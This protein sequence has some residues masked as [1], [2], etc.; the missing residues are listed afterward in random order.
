MDLNHKI[1]FGALFVA[2]FGIVKTYHLHKR[3]EY[4]EKIVDLMTEVMELEFE[5]EIDQKFEEIIDNLDEP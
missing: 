5:K 2:C 4:L 1:A 3:V